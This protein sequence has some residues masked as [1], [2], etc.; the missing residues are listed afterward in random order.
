MEKA[1]D[2]T[3]Q[4]FNNRSGNKHIM[5]DKTNRRIILTA[6][7]IVLAII[8]IF[9]GISLYLTPSRL[10]RIINEEA[11]SRLAADVRVSDVKYSLWSSFPNLRVS[12][13]SVIVDSRS[14]DGLPHETMS[15]LP[16]DSKRLFTSGRISGSVNILKALRGDIELRDV[17]IV[18]PSCNLVAV[19]DS[20]NNYNIFPPLK[21]KLKIPHL[22]FITIK[23]GSPV[24]VR[25]FDAESRMSADAVVDHAALEV[26]KDK[27]D[28]YKVSLSGGIDVK[29]EDI[30]TLRSV[31]L[32]IDA[33][34]ALGFTPFTLTVTGCQANVADL[35]TLSDLTVIADDN[36]VIGKLNLDVSCPD[37]MAVTDFFAFPDESSLNGIDGMLPLFATL[38]LDAPYE[39]A[40]RSEGR[41]ELPAFSLSVNVPQGNVSYPVKPGN[42]IHMNAIALQADVNIDPSNPS[43]S[44]LLIPVARLEAEGADVEVSGRVTELM[45]GD[46][47]LDAMIKCN[48]DLAQS[49]SKIMP[50]NKMKIEGIIEG[51]TSVSCHLS[52]LKEKALRDVN[53]NG[54]FKIA[55]L[56]INDAVTRMTAALQDLSLKL[57]G[58]IPQLSSSGIGDSKLNLIVSSGKGSIA[59]GSDTT[60]IKYKDLSFSGQFGAKGSVGNP[61]LG[62]NMTAS[63]GQLYTSAPGIKFTARGIDLNLAAAMRHVP[64]S[65]SASYSTAPSSADDSILSHRVD[66]TPIYLIPSVPYMLQTGL[67]LINMKADVK[68]KSGELLAEGYPVHNEFSDVDM[69]T[70]LDEL[71]IKSMNIS[72]RGADA[73]LSGKVSGLRNFLMSSSAVPLKIDMDARFSNVD[74]NRLSGN[75]Y[76]GQSLLSGKPADYHVAPPGAY[77]A[78]DSLCVLI[79]RNLY[80]D[81]RLRSD[82]AEYMGWQFS[83]LSTD[84]TLHDGVA[85]LGDLCIGSGFGAVN[86]DWTYST[87]DLNDIFMQLNVGV[88][89]F[90]MSRFFKTFPTIVESTPELENLSGNLSAEIDGKALMFP[91]MFVNAPSMTAKVDVHSSGLEFKRE[92]KMKRITNLMLFK[93]DAPIA[94]D[95]FDIHGSFHNNM[96]QL[97]PFVIGCG[98]YKLGVAGVN[99]LQGEMYYHLGLHGSPFHMPFGVNLVGNWKHPQLRFG[100][101]GVKDG[102]E[103]EIASDLRDNVNVN[104]MR[105][106]KY[107]WLL[108][109]E[110]A[111]KYD[112]ENNHEYVFNVY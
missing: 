65:A 54:D 101:A 50:A 69:S 27:K 104:I 49:L 20:I 18:K 36:I 66:H 83:P 14:L 58:S 12:I 29:S 22:S 73:R 98:P 45:S 43:A 21:K 77:T 19:N 13:G 41:P 108:F 100:G 80:A 52:G 56:K 111:A 107:G 82:R 9:T 64:W 53:M 81:V 92:G 11:S 70:N 94:T 109:V 62:G 112:A 63:A 10:Q 26:L 3:I 5:S 32:K 88:K 28:N 48:A 35:K 37:V 78:A 34:I 47:Y 106:L 17:E 75:Y 8:L 42:P 15:K 39:V 99:N 87:S 102:R 71:K 91:D 44:S 89:D 68:I 7:G 46:P 2:K 72:T 85:T 79:P 16:E 4:D 40:T 31:P 74:I 84:I 95:T 59:N 97:D 76:A 23:I 60:V 57:R 61:T 30:S 90:D 93:G 24:T 86:I 110:A 6:G 51:A 105:Q 38:K 25:W 55:S 33:D 103:R 96:L 1:K 67:S